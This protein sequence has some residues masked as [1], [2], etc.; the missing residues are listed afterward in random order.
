MLN[1]KLSCKAIVISLA[2]L[3]LVS[4]HAETGSAEALAFAQQVYDRPN[5][6]DSSSRVTMTLKGKNQSTRVRELSIYSIDK[7]K[8][9]RW[10]LMR[11][12][13]P[14]DIENT[15][16]LTKD[17]PG[18]DSDQ[19]IY[20]P[21]LDRVRVISSNRKGGRFVGSDFTYEDLRDREPD[22]DKHRLAGVDTVGK[23]KCE[24][25]ES[26]PVDKDNSIYSKRIS[27]IHR[28]TLTPLRV[29]FFKKGR[30]QPVKRMLARKLKKI[31]G[32]WT[33]LESTMY[34]LK[35]G[36]QTIL[37]TTKIKYD[38][39]IPEQLF[40]KRGL[41]DPDREKRFEQ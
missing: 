9:E 16:L 31:Q 15:G 33:V 28:G 6:K 23:I 14:T 26:I 27:C 34:D 21:A 12:S 41:S 29:E 8:G 32:Y 1:I 13:L 38:L 37:E 30:K 19:W 40:S 25:L 11:F 3:P 2:M 20:L 17:H 35:N 24:L 5:G 7:G 22:M 18:D 4:L 10:S 39:G 36:S